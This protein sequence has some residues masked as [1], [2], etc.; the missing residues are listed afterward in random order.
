MHPYLLILDNLS[1]LLT[2]AIVLCAAYAHSKKPTDY[3][4]Y[5]ISGFEARHVVVTASGML[6]WFVLLIR[7]AS[8]E[9]ASSSYDRWWH[10]GLASMICQIIWS[11]IVVMVLPYGILDNVDRI[12]PLD[13]ALLEVSVTSTRCPSFLTFIRE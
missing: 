9:W 6:N 3:S 5:S 1:Y 2:M 7:H 8:W 10:F 4:K 12:L 11:G 13:V